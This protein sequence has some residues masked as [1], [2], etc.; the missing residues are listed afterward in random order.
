[1]TGRI[2]SVIVASVLGL[3]ASQ[4][5]ASIELVVNGGFETGDFT[6][7]TST[8]QMAGLGFVPNN[9]SFNPP[10]PGSPLPP[11]AGGFDAVS[12]QTSPAVNSLTQ[13]VTVPAGV[14]SAVFSW[15][16]RIR[17]FANGGF[18]DPNQELRVLLE[19]T[20]GGLIQEVFSTD[21]GDPRQVIGPI[22][23]TFDLTSVLQGWEGQDVQ[24]SFEQQDNLG[25][26]NATIDDVS[27]VV[28]VASNGAIPEPTMLMIWAGLACGTIAPAARRR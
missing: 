10:G 7:W 14:V 1:M 18:S 15:S 19:D 20:S 6:G 17:N 16:D 23:R 4:A 21:P 26:L 27:L 8:G 24:I 28:D 5:R 2:V 13:V 9:G 12:A 3:A 22:A 11:I 25:F